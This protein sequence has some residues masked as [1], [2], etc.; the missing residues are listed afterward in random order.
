MTTW[1]HT[2]LLPFLALIFF[3]CGILSSDDNDNNGID[4]YFRS[5]LNGEEWTVFPR[6]TVDKEL[7]DLAIWGEKLYPDYWRE[8]LSIRL[9]FIGPGKYDMVWRR[10]DDYDGI[11]IGAFYSEADYDVGIARYY[12]RTND[13]T[14]FMEIISY[15]EESRIIEGT[16]HLT[17]VIEEEWEEKVKR[18]EELGIN[19]PKRRRPDT[20]F[21]ING[22]F[23]VLVEERWWN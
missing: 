14:N 2:I 15:D 10:A 22:R 12:A 21:F 4:Q 11:S 7:T 6:A 19:Y 16:F 8:T 20:L 9:R 3:G 1:I 17:L 13:T 5:N 23:R 18:W